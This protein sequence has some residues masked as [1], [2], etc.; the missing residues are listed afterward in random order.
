MKKL[1]VV[2]GVVV[3]VVEIDMAAVP[4]WAAAWPDHV[5][6][7]DIGWVEDEGGGF[8]PPPLSEA[9]E[10][11]LWADV[12]QKRNALL[13]ACDWTQLSDVS[14]T[15]AERSAWQVY[16]QALRDITE[17]EDPSALTWPVA[18]L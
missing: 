13:A 4:D 8:V 3:N 16:R 2:D 14:V 17:S 5:A 18:P 6:G 1:Q 11:Q 10:S 9:D 7:V 15:E 12:R